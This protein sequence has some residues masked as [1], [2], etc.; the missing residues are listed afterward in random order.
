MKGRDV[1]ATVAEAMA[2]LLHI[3]D[4]WLGYA[5]LGAGLW[6]AGHVACALW[7]GTGL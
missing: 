2:E 3:L 7:R 6:F 5:A 1:L 4:R